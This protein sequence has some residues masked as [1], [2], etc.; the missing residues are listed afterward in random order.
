VLARNNKHKMAKFFKYKGKPASGL[1]EPVP[2]G[3][4]R[5]K[6][7]SRPRF[8]HSGE[9]PNALADSGRGAT[10]LELYPR[11]KYRQARDGEVSLR[12][13]ASDLADHV[14]AQEH[15]QRSRG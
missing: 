9:R 11:E 4:Q 8:L 3:T 7:S 1:Q 2:R 10:V 13:Y 12:E 15:R 14:A 6:P 5:H